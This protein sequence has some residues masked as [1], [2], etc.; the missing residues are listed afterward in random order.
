MRKL[1]GALFVATLLVTTGFAQGTNAGKI[2]IGI[3]GVTSPNLEAKYFFTDNIASEFTFGANIYSPGGDAA[4]GQ[5]K[6]TGTDIRVGLS[7]LYHFTTSTFS[8]YLGVEGLYETTKD[9]GF[10]V[11]EPD[12]KN[13]VQ[14]NLVF[15]GEYFI[16]KQFSVG[17]KEKA[18]L[19]FGLSRDYPDEKSDTHF[20]TSTYVTAKF[21][22]N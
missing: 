7:V 2:G 10:Y 14:T 20:A 12:A 4:Q 11:K 1:L 13:Y 5:T 16:A 6:V 8:P 15:G 18:G 9:A 21:Y 22:F 3:D 19:L 17:I